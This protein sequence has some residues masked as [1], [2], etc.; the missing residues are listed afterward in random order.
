[1]AKILVTGGAGFIGSHL[2][3]ALIERGH[4]VKIIDNLSTGKKEYLNSQAEFYQLDIRDFKKIRPLFENIDF[5]FHLAALPRIQPSIQNP[6]ESNEINIAGTLNILFSAKEAG[7][8]KVIYSASSSAYGDQNKLPL[9]EV[10]PPNLK[11]PY[12]LQ[13]V[14][15]EMYCRLFSQLYN[16]PTV[17][18]RYFNVYGSRQ[19][20]ESAYATV[21]GIFLKQKKEGRPLTIVGDGEQRRDYTYVSDVV[22]ANIL[23]MGKEIEKGKIINIGTGRNYSVNELAQMIGGQTKNIPPRPGESKITLADNNL[24]KE[25]LGWQPTVNLPDWIKNY[26]REMRL[27]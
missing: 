24:A 13:K 14:V 8:K 16:L 18:L 23:A 17:C 9:K 20:C 12:A 19:S 15:G 10:M 2:V 11:N 22:K 3:D 26:K 5:V 25:L 6:L 21:I 27:K 1:M 7:I 4:S